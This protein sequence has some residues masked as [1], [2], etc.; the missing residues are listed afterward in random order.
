VGGKKQAGAVVVVWG[1]AHG[2]DFAKRS[3]ITQNT[4]YIAGTAETND[5]FPAT[6]PTGTGSTLHTV[7]DLGLGDRPYFGAA[8]AD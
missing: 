6:G 4:P 5:F 1:T 3:V 7:K 8:L 2:P